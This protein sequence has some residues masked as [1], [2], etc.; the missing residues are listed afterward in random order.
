LFSSQTFFV[1][2]LTRFWGWPLRVNNIVGTYM[3]GFM[4]F[5]GEMSAIE[6]WAQKESPGQR[7]AIAGS[8]VVARLCCFQRRSRALN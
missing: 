8:T 1:E 5:L 4:T 3:R 2:L 6:P 7:F